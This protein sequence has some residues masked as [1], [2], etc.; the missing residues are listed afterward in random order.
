MYLIFDSETETHHSHK[1]KSNPFNPK[2]YVVMRGYKKQGDQCC[3]AEHFLSKDQVTPLHI[4]DD[5]DVLVGHNIKFDLL[6]EMCIPGGYENLRKFYVRGGKVW[7]TQYAEYLIRGQVQKYHM[8]SMDSIIE[9]YGGRKKIDG[10]KALWN[11]GVLTSEINPDLL[12]D[13]LIGTVEEGRNSGDIGNTELIY[14]GQLKEA[15]IL[16]MRTAIEVRMDG[17]LGTTE[18]EYRGL[19]IDL[20]VAKA[21]MAALMA[22]QKEVAARLDAYITEHVPAEVNFSWTSGTHVSCLLFGGTIKYEKRDVY[23]DETGELARYKATERWPL[24]NGKPI[25]LSKLM[26]SPSAEYDDTLARWTIKRPNGSVLVQDVYKSGKKVGEGKF[27]NVEVQ[28]DLKVKWQDYFHKLPG[29]TEPDPSWK[30]AMTD[31][32]GVPIYSTDKDTIEVLGTRDIPFLKDFSRNAAL[33]KELGTYYARYDPKKKTYVGMLTTVDETGVVHHSLNHVNTVTSRLS[34]NNPNMQNLPRADKS[35][36]KRMFIS[37]FKDGGQMVEIDYSQLEVVVQGLLS[38]D[39]NLVK[40]LINQ[41]D[42][43]CKRVAL[44]HQIKYED[45]IYWC[46]DETYPEYKKWKKERTKAK[47]FSFQRAYGAGAAAIAASTGMDVDEVKAM[48]EAEEQEYAGV[49]RYNDLVEREV[50]STAEPFRDGEQGWRVFRRGTYTAP[51]GTIYSFR[52]YDAPKWMRDKGITDTFMPTELKNYPIQGTGGEIV[53]MVLGVM[54]RLFMRKN[55]WDNRAFLV[56]TVHDCY[57]IDTHPDVTREVADAVLKV[58]NAVP[59]L[60]KKFYN[61]E[62]PVPFP[63]E[64]EHGPNMYD[65]THFH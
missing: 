18:M 62:C 35:T 49:K 13:Y 40:D 23:I 15:D 65:L 17:L 54:F 63:A 52:S 50:N 20:A 1:R 27:T 4:P 5:V 36:V 59:Q 43:H 29:I 57:W 3:T 2:N 64:A 48:I 58:M 56:N 6:Y 47:N 32:A 28:G 26:A 46:K 53:Q 41:V 21:D 60:L 9:S 45:A 61:I 38:N 11:A 22:E 24:F 39:A 30:N 19:P 51:T 16:G 34:S 25:E 10:L 42:F 12:K 37:R 55:N 7:C 44:K 8:V 31:G 14:L 33:N